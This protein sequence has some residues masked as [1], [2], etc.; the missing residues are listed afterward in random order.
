MRCTVAFVDHVNKL[1][2][3]FLEYKSVSCF[4]IRIIRITLDDEVIIRIRRITMENSLGLFVTM[5]NK[6]TRTG[7]EEKKVCRTIEGI[8]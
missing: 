7:T 4:T 5:M 8:R 3:F 6:T 1:F 2:Q